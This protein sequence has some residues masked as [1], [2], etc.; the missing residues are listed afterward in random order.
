[1]IEFDGA[2]HLHVHS[3]LELFELLMPE[4]SPMQPATVLS[5]S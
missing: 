1:V 4:W 3:S 5:A 2:Y